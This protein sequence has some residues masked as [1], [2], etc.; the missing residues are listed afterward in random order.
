MVHLISFVAAVENSRA[1]EGQLVACYPY[2]D[3]VSLQLQFEILA[4][5]FGHCPK[6]L[7]FELGQSGGD[8]PAS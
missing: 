5:A 4:V 2:G 1:V 6:V 3:G 8:I 7:D